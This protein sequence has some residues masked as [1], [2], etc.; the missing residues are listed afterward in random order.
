MSRITSIEDLQRIARAKG[1]NCLSKVYTGK[2]EKLL[3]KCRKGHEWKAVPS[4]VKHGTWCPYCYGRGKTIRDMQRLAQSRGGRCLSSKYTNTRTKLRWQCRAGH[5]WTTIPKCIL[6]GHW[7]PQCDQ[8]SRPRKYTIVDLKKIAV[9]RGGKCLSQHY[10][11]WGEKLEWQCSKGHHWWAR[12]ADVA[13]KRGRWCPYC[14]GLHITITDMHNLARQRGGRCLAKQYHGAS[15]KLLWECAKGHR[16][17]AVPASVKTGTWCP[18]CAGNTSYSIDDMHSLAVKRGGKCLSKCYRNS[19]TVLLWECAEGHRWEAKAG[20]VRTG[21]WCPKCAETIGE[22]I[23]RT[24]FEQLFDAEFPKSRP[25]WLR[26]PTGRKLELDGYSE[27]LHLAF[28]HQG[29]HHFTHDRYFAQS[30]KQF[31]KQ[32]AHD[33]AK[34]ALCRKQGVT[35]I[36][37]PEV[38]RLLPI[39]KVRHHIRAECRKA[40]YRLP[41]GFDSVKL[42]TGKAYATSRTRAA[43]TRLAK[44]AEGYGGRC[45]SGMYR[46]SAVPLLWQCAK[47]HRW[48]ASP[49]S[50]KGGTWCLR[51]AGGMRK[52]G[53]PRRLTIAGM[54]AVAKG[55]GGRCLSRSCRNAYDR[56]R[57]ECA[58]GHRWQ[59]HAGRV[60]T[61]GQWCAKCAGVHRLTLA[62]MRKAAKA[63]GGRCLSTEYINGRTKLHWRCAEGH[64]WRAVPGSIRQG[65]W[66]PF[67]GFKRRVLTRTGKTAPLTIERMRQVAAERGGICLSDVYRDTKTKLRWRCNQSHEWEATYNSIR[68]GAW[69]RSCRK[70]G[71]TAIGGNRSREHNWETARA[72]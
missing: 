65:T 46:G 22:R 28:E 35:L 49:A 51:C 70:A 47:G 61:H 3:W 45:V 1:G 71:I 57:W 41:L 34:I 29:G 55:H 19:S 25:D 20:N 16:W 33:A 40:G 23:C 9:K 37:V 43:M 39:P 62:D 27:E 60:F 31:R 53:T 11:G 8:L 4:S 32:L 12:P 6:R 48:S 50:I 52:D 54:H 21:T 10:L 69:C 63:N 36:Q 59:A 24:A 64:E 2:R 26:G 67:C 14:R 13:A 30:K 44:I 72:K 17:K 42:N 7:C 68:N 58:K 18:E 38:P 66:C 56:L 15:S 5:K